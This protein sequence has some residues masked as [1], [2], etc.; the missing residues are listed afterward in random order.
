M[1]LKRMQYFCT[2]FEQGNISKAARLL[3]MAAPPLGKRLQE[4]EQELGVPLFLR[5]GKTLQPTEAGTF[6]YHHARDILGKVNEVKNKTARFSTSDKKIIKIGLSYLFLSRFSVALNQLQHA[7]PHHLL[8]ITV[9]DSSHLESLLRD[10]NL[11]VA[12][13]QTPKPAPDFQVDAL[14]PVP[15]MAL[16]AKNLLTPTQ[17]GHTID[18]I[19]LSHLP[20]LLLQRLEGQGTLETLLQLFHDANQSLNVLMKASDPQL[21]VSLLRQGSEA[22]AILPASEIPS[23]LPPHCQALT[24]HPPLSLFR[25]AVVTLKGAQIAD[26]W[27]RLLTQ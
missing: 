25:P 1:D 26:E 27:L 21:I 12:L 23:Q 16:V 20:L 13:M 22:C 4:L 24:I 3:N 11:D 5:R 10:K 8:H 7:L 15:A 14:T 6:L 9:S 2:V 18:L 17:S 19:A